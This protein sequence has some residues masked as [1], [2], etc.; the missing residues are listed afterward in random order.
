[1]TTIITDC[2]E[3]TFSV[4]TLDRD[5]IR[6]QEFCILTRMYMHPRTFCLLLNVISLHGTP[7]LAC[8]GGVL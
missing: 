1:M 6:G 2:R 5:G 3:L 7:V 8:I 4:L